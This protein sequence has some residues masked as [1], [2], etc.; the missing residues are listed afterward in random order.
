MFQ[1]GHFLHFDDRDYERLGFLLKCN[2]A[3]KTAVDRETI[4][5]ALAEGRI[6]VLATDHA[7]HLMKKRR[8]CTTKRA[9]ACR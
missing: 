8:S 9:P 2:P 3:L 6:D 1:P 5:R 4:T 7:P